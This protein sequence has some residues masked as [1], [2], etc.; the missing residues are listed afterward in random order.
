MQIQYLDGLTGQLRVRV[1]R[2][3]PHRSSVE[4]RIG[5]ARVAP[6]ILG[7]ASS[8]QLRGINSTQIFSRRSDVARVTVPAPK[9]RIA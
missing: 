7:L 8:A 2:T 6:G 5:A 1:W 3:L 9:P 4:R